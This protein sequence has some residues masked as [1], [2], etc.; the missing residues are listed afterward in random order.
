[1]KRIILTV[2]ALGMFAAAQR[3]EAQEFQVVVNAGA[4]LTEISRKDLSNIF[5]KKKNELPSGER[6]NPVDLSADADVRE[7]FSQAVHR[8]SSNQIAAY[9]QQ[10]IFSGR[11]V[12]PE[13]KGSDDEVIAYVS[14]TPGAIGYVS[15]SASLGSGVKTLT[16]SN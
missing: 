11:G 16:V 1:M 5:Q 4:S 14:S 2:A 9:W 12:P 10:Q 13:E 15:A 8:R 6:A 3:L 7:S